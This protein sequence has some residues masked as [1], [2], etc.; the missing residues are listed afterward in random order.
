[1]LPT[2]PLLA[3]LLLDSFL[4]LIHRIFCAA[5]GDIGNYVLFLLRMLTSAEIKS[6]ADFFSPFIMGLS[7]MVGGT[8]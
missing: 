6:R 8:A 1:M 7:D 2:Q 3:L 5:A 4:N